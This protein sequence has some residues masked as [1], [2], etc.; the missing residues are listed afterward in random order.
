[1]RTNSGGTLD[2][3]SRTNP[4]AAINPVPAAAVSSPTAALT[5]PGDDLVP[6]GM[7]EMESESPTGVV[8]VY[9]DADG[10]RRGRVIIEQ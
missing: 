5:L 2:C 10:R 6:P 9:R 1:M 3:P 8:F 4:Y 7:P